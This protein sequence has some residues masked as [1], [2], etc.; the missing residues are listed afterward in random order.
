MVACA[1]YITRTVMAILVFPALSNF[2]VL[3]FIHLS[4]LFFS[5]AGI[6]SAK[7]ATESEFNT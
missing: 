2:V 1:G 7:M 5:K 6:I 4:A 3:D